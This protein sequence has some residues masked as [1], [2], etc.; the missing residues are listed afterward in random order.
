M[1]LKVAAKEVHTAIQEATQ[2]KMA[3][4]LLRDLKVSDLLFSDKKHMLLWDSF[5]RSLIDW[6]GTI[7]DPF[8]TNEHPNLAITLQNFWDMIFTD[9]DLNVGEFLAIR[10]IVSSGIPLLLSNSTANHTGDL[11]D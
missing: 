9:L 7:N 11:T 5:I 6:A 1:G 8:G 2:D 3:R 4:R 10:K